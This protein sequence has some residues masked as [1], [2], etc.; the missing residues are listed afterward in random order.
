[1]NKLRGALCSI[2]GN[3]YEKE[4]HNIVKKCTLNDI[5]FNTQNINQLGGSKSCND[6]S[7]RMLQKDIGIEIKKFNTPDWM[8]CSIKYNNDT[9][10]WFGSKNGKIPEGARN[11]FDELINNIEIFNNE[12]PIFLKYD[13]TYEEWTLLKKDT[14]KWNDI[15]IEIP[16]DTIK[17]LY[18]LKNCYYIQI[19]KYGLY[20]LGQ[21]ICGFNVP[22]FNIK[23]RMRIRIKVHTRKNKRGYCKLSVT[24]ACQ[25]NNIK[26]LDKSQYTLDHI[27]KLPINLIYNN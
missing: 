11:V 4:I 19:S 23:Q 9:K 20:H 5:A 6:L 22:E 14:K 10:Q 16:N 3:K 17:K 27:N 13:I 25:P 15:Y 2:N 8:Q 26:T 24:A 7:C 1:M 18:S 21:D 12:I